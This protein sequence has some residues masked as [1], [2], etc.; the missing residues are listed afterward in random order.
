MGD[1]GTVNGIYGKYFPENPPA[2]A[3]FAVKTLP[4]NAKVRRGRWV[5]LGWGH[6]RCFLPAAKGKPAFAAGR[7]AAAGAPHP[8]I[9]LPVAPL[10]WPRPRLRLRPSPCSSRRLTPLRTDLSSRGP[11][12]CNCNE[13]FIHNGMRTVGARFRGTVPIAAGRHA[14][15]LLLPYMGWPSWQRHTRQRHTRQRHTRQRHTRQRHTRQR[16]TP[17]LGCK[18]GWRQPSGSGHTCCQPPVRRR[19]L[20]ASSQ[21]AEGRM[22][23]AAAARRPLRQAKQ[24]EASWGI[25]GGLARWLQPYCAHQEPLA[26]CA[27]QPAKAPLDRP[28]NRWRERLPTPPVQRLADAAAGLDDHRGCPTAAAAACAAA[29]VSAVAADWVAAC[30]AHAAAVQQNWIEGIGLGARR[31]PLGGGRLANSIH[32]PSLSAWAAALPA[33]CGG[34]PSSAFSRPSSP[35]PQSPAAC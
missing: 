8:H 16:H 3:T 5:R 2:R 28:R 35:P 32:A 7:G 6:R 33:S 18:L 4:L 9:P 24:P 29:H 10:R 15:C 11:V 31:T 17:V 20:Q 14:R 27:A 34:Y 1:F 12:I 21:G 23:D 30:G 13:Y 22:K 19:G 26:T 25:E